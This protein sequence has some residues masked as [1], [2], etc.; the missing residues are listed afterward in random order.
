MTP[1][2]E[3]RIVQDFNKNYALEIKWMNLTS[4]IDIKKLSGVY[5]FLKKIDESSFKVLY[6]GESL[7][8]LSRFSDHTKTQFYEE[9]TH[10]VYSYF[11]REVDRK[12]NEI[13]LI[14]YYNPEYNYK[15][16]SKLGTANFI[17]K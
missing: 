10:F 11:E 7:N 17:W 16:N 9:S 15:E 1:E 3:L 6:V 2:Q 13:S 4:P 5:M 12:M 8:V 14:Q